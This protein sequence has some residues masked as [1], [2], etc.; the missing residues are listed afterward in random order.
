MNRVTEL[1]NGVALALARR[2]GDVLLVLRCPRQGRRALVV[3]AAR[4]GV[5]ELAHPLAQRA[6]DLRHA[7]SAEEEQDDDEEDEDLGKPDSEGHK[8]TLAAVSGGL[9]PPDPHCYD[10]SRGGRGARRICAREPFGTTGA[11]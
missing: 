4:H 11:E 10:G 8:A 6:T 5:L 3:V 1:R 7:G 2:R 9:G